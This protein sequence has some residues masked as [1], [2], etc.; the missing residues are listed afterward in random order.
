MGGELRRL[1][2]CG[3]VSL[4]GSTASR[5]YIRPVLPEFPLAA[6]CCQRKRTVTARR[7]GRM[8][9]WSVESQLGH[10]SR[11]MSIRIVVDASAMCRITFDGWQTF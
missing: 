7:P 10:V 6:R 8:P 11:D 9:V 2:I 4:G 3:V 1:P 5:K